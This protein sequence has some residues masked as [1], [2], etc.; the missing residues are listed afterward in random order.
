MGNDG[1]TFRVPP[2][3]Q[4]RTNFYFLCLFLMLTVYFL[5]KRFTRSPVGAVLVAI[6]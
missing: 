4:D 1:F 2:V 3:L 5:L 6:R